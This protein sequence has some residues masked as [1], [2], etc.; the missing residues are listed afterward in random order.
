M[1]SHIVVAVGENY[2]LWLGGQFSRGFEVSVNGRHVG[3][4]KNQLSGF[5]AYVPVAS[6]YLAPGVHTFVLTYPHA[7]LSPGSSQS[8]YTQ[9]AAI[10]LEPETPSAQLLT[11]L[12]HEAKL[13]CGKSLDWLEVVKRG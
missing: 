12:P 8:L 13:L 7:S 3:T 11:V 4:V 10:A 1:T 9:L 2:Q 6:V 5:K